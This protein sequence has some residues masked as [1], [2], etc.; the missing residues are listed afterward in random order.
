MYAIVE[1]G[2]KQFKVTKGDQIKVEKAISERTRKISLDKVLLI[3][4]DKSV[5]IG[6]PYLKNAKVDCEVISFIKGK[7]KIAYKFRRRKSS[8]SKRGSRQKLVLLEVKEIHE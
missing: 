8:D 7:K 4:K 6:N 2:N 5:N 3:A 1:I